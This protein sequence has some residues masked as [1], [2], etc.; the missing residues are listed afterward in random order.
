MTVTEERITPPTTAEPTRRLRSII[1]WVIVAALVVG[2]AWVGL[3]IAAT[4]PSERRSL[5]PEGRG[6]AGAL[7]LAEILRDQGVEV[8]VY[9]SHVEARDALDESTTLVM[10][11]PYT[12]SDD[13]LAELMGPADRVVFLSVGAHLLDELD[14]GA[15]SSAP[16]AEVDAQCTAG[17][18]AEVGMIEPDRLMTPHSGVEWCFGDEEGAAVLIDDSDGRRTSIVDGSRL[19]SNAY[20]AENGNAALALALLG[21]TD[22]V[23]WY[24]PSLGDSDL[25]ATSP[26]TLGTLTPPW[27]TPAIILLML[28]GAAA[29]LWRGRRFGPLVAETLPVTVRASETMHGRARLTAKA[30]DAPHAALAIRDGAQRRL[31]RRLGL[32][33]RA[34]SDEVADAAS[35]RLRIPRGT[36]QAL[37]A[38]PLP[39]DDAALV[40][41]A[42]RLADLEE[43]VEKTHRTARATDAP[44]AHTPSTTE[45]E[46]TRDR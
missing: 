45:A 15:Y 4:A 25:E 22:R 20:L 19:F 5:D 42:R 9:R 31:A 30:A 1:G 8:D 6:D 10:T 35:D 3:Q 16:L 40:E 14:L 13:G 39:T 11:N 34:T 46:D 7:A 27:V 17:E 43:A 38:G 41:L 36:L 24:V 32:T 28:S 33:A 37:L 44:S 12:L 26:D 2:V 29:A 18:F 23:V 21:Q